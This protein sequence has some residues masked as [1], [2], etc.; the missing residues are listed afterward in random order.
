MAIDV[1]VTGAAGA[2]GRQVVATL[3][4]SGYNVIGTGRANMDGVDALWD[5]SRDSGPQP[6]CQPTVVV[7]AAAQVGRHGHTLQDA[8]PLFDVNV[9]G[10]LRVAQWCASKGVNQLV[11]ISGA[12]VY[13]EW[14]GQP[15]TESNTAKPSSAGSY[16]V[17]KWCGEQLLSL[18]ANTRT[19]VTTLR[20]TSLFGLGYTQGLIPALLGQARDNGMVQLEPPFDDSFDLLHLSDAA[21]T[22]QRAIEAQRSGL[23]NVG[24]GGLCTINDIAGACAAPFDAQVTLSEAPSQR[25]AR[26]INWVDDRRARTEL[27]HRNE[28]SLEQGITELGH[29]MSDGKAGNLSA[30]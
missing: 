7:H 8:T 20:L 25:P 6:D 11:Y 15:K 17:S 3:G 18:L 26:I 2:L 22:V 21:R 14:S 13:G 30:I 12:L 9:T 1:L 28:M 16:A 5:L 24:S 4:S 29:L 10:T 19:T 27:G 23:W